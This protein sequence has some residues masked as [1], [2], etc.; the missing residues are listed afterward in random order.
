MTLTQSL[1]HTGYLVMSHLASIL[2]RIDL[3]GILRDRRT[4]IPYLSER[5]EIGA[6]GDSTL[7]PEVSD[8]FLNAICRTAQAVDGHLCPRA[9]LLAY[10]FCDGGSALD[11][12]FH[13]LILR[14]LK[15]L[16]SRNEI[17]GVGPQGCRSHGYHRRTSRTI[18]T[19]DKLTP[20]PMVGHILSLMRIGTWENKR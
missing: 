9:T 5:V 3:Y 17:T 19:G 20:L 1:A 8:K 16:L 2:H 11:L 4:V 13:Q 18:E 15:L 12:Q 6:E 10:P 14:I 7:F